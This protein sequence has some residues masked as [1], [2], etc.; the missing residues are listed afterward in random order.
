MK[1]KGVGSTWHLLLLAGCATLAAP[2]EPFDV[3]LEVDFGPANQPAIRRLVQVE[4]GATP[5]V[6]TAKVF[7]V[8]KGAVCCDPRETASIGGVAADQEVESW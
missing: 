8:E 2:K 5:E 3:A 6:L 1:P 4:R 7:P